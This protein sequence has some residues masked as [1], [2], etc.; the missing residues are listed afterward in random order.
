MLVKGHQPRMDAP[1]EG[2]AW[3]TIGT[4]GTDAN[5]VDPILPAFFF[6][7]EALNLVGSCQLVCNYAIL[8]AQAVQV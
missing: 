2:K 4:N 3:E 8:L 6:H 1:E 7:S 5:K